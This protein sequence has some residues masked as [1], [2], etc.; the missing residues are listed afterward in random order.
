M[1]SRHQT[2]PRPIDHFSIFVAIFER[3]IRSSR[4]RRQ[5][6]PGD[7]IAPAIPSPCAAC[8][9]ADTSCWSSADSLSFTA[10]SPQH[11]R[12]M[13]AT[14]R[15]IAIGGF[16]EIHN[17]NPIAPGSNTELV[18]KRTDHLRH[19]ATYPLAAPFHCAR[20]HLSPEQCKSIPAAS[21][22]P[23]RW[24]IAQRARCAPSPP[25]HRPQYPTTLRTDRAGSHTLPYFRLD[26]LA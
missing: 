16:I 26:I 22:S 24:Q 12:N 9:D 3:R 11:A 18:D 7:S 10:G 15:R 1:P 2:S 19:A 5:R 14:V 21:R 4:P 6:L 8:S 23:G 17:Q 13:A 20:R 25:S